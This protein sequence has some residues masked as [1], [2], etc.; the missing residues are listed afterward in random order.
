MNEAGAHK[1]GRFNHKEAFTRGR[2]EL[3]KK[4]KVG[5]METGDKDGQILSSTYFSVKCHTPIQQVAPRTY[6]IGSSPPE[7]GTVN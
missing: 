4:K 5:R 2:Y 1:W 3:V 7:I 6:K